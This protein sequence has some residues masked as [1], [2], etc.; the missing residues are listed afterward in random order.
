M[1][2]I[3]RQ[4]IAAA[5]AAAAGVAHAQGADTAWYLGIGAGGANYADSIP[6]QIATA[7]AGNGTF[8]F[9]NATTTDS[10][11]TANQAFVGYRFLP[12][13]AASNRS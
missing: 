6:H 2:T 8:E 7:Y 5:L 4:V 1:Q 10:S 11:D 13:L 3:F 9:L 12:W